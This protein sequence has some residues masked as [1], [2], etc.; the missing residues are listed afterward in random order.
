M[1]RFE[2]YCQE[3]FLLYFFNNYVT[4]PIDKNN[5][6]C[7]E[8]FELLLSKAEICVDSTEKLLSETSNPLLKH[9]IKMSTSGGSRIIHLPYQF[10]NISEDVGSLFVSNPAPLYYLSNH[11]LGCLDNYGIQISDTTNFLQGIDRISQKPVTYRVHSNREFNQF[12]GWD[13]MLNNLPPRNSIVIA[14]NYFLDN[15]SIYPQNLYKMLTMLL[16]ESI[17]HQDFHLTIITKQDLQNPQRKFDQ[18]TKFLTTLNRNYK[19]RFGLF[20]TAVNRPHDRDLISNYFRIKIGY[21]FDI[22]NERGFPKRD[23]EINYIPINSESTPRAHFGLLKTLAS[24]T[25]DADCLGSIE[26]RLL[27]YFR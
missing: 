20:R 11:S 22:F 25:K 18:I 21:S 9:L 24:Y 23:T 27:E 16:P 3:D 26:N 5:H 10:H 13:T 1:E 7:N 4:N 14:D 15:E 8:L 19:I 17:N 2:T 12:N 6:R